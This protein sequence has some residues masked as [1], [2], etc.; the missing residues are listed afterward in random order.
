MFGALEEK[1][2]V[3]DWKCCP[4][5][6]CSFN[7]YDDAVSHAFQRYQLLYFQLTCW[8]C[9]VIAIRTFVELLFYHA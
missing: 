9:H 4:W 8:Q 7:A 6:L 1:T 3:E 5:Q 2:A